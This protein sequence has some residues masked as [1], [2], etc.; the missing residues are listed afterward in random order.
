MFFYFIFLT[1]SLILRRIFM[2]CV[3]I[4]FFTKLFSIAYVDGKIPSEDQVP[5]FKRTVCVLF[6]FL[7]NF[8]FQIEIWIVVRILLCRTRLSSCTIHCF[9]SNNSIFSILFFLFSIKAD[10][11]KSYHETKW[12]RR[13][14]KFEIK[15]KKRIYFETCWFLFKNV[16]VTNFTSIWHQLRVIFKEFF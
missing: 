10:I 3:V 2:F 6:L 14:T 15:R 4:K 5:V 9:G 7:L 1:F 8:Y 16:N 12:K 11:I 13:L